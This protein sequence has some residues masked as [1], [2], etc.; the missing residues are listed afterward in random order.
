MFRAIVT[1]PSGSVASSRPVHMPVVGDD[2]APVKLPTLEKGEAAT[3]FAG[4]LKAEYF[5]FASPQAT[6]PSLAGL[7]PQKT[8][9]VTA[10]NQPNP[11]AIFGDDPLGAAMQGDFAA[12]FS[13]DLWAESGGY[14]NFWLA[15]RNGAELRIDGKTVAAAGVSMGSPA[16]VAGAATLPPGWH[17]VEVLYLRA[18]GMESVRLEWAQPGATREVV[19]PQYFRTALDGVS[20]DR[21]PA[22]F[23]S[24]WVRLQQ[25]S[26]TREMFV[27][28]PQ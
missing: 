12:R 5:G 17:R 9:F 22:M 11:G 19:S 27:R 18:V 26:G 25:A 6:M 24:V 15:A 8:G 4:G 2:G 28:P 7:A 1:L 13:G 3:L 20:V 16:E 14:Y 10:V 23:D 21:V